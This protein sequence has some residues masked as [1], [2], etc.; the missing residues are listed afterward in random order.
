MLLSLVDD[1]ADVRR[2]LFKFQGPVRDCR[3]WDHH[4]EGALNS[5]GLDQVAEQGDS[6]DRLAQPHLV[7]QDSVQVVVEERDHPVETHKLVGFKLPTLEH[8]G[9][10]CD[11]LFDGV[12]YRVVVLG[13]I[14]HVMLYFVCVSLA[15]LTWML[16]ALRQF[17]LLLNFGGSALLVILLL[18]V[19]L[20]SFHQ[21]CCL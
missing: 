13:G 4:Q 7:C 17:G 19:P 1:D 16:F 12:C 2:P 5:L 8:I 15:F 14:L 3:E 18:C 10:L 9:L 20:C 21:S 11:F 6:L